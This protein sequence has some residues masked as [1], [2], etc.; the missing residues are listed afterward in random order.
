AA[1]RAG[2]LLVLDGMTGKLLDTL[3]TVGLPLKARNDLTDRIYL[4]D[5][6][7]LIQCLHEPEQQKPIL[8]DKDR[9]QTEEI[10][11]DA[12]AKGEAKKPAAK[13]PVKSSK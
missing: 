11:T 5:D 1:D 6:F 13:K 10:Q 8:H 12:A 3:P 9:P 4:A 2:R 7:G